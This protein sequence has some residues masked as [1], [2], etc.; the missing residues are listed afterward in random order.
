MQIRIGNHW[1]EV[2]DPYG[3]VWER[4]KEL[5]GLQPQRK[6]NI[7]TNLDPWELTET[8]LQTKEHTPA[9]PKTLEH[10]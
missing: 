2:F 9:G 6:A 5:K 7:A 3:I 1:T 4:F 10:M 8:N